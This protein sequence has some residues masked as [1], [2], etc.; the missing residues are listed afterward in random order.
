VQAGGGGTAWLI[1]QIVVAN[2][3]AGEVASVAPYKLTTRNEI[4]K[5]KKRS[6]YVF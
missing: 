6:L 4:P 5:G 3:Q 2:I 1:H